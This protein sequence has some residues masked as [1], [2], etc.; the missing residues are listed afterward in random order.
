MSF[1]PH[2]LTLRQLQYVVAIAETRSFREA[3]ERCHV[4]QPALSAQLA[5]LEDA[6]G[7]RIFDRDARRVAA[8]T[9]GAEIVERAKAALR[10]ADEV[11]EAA[12]RVR[13]PLDGRLR[14]GVIPTVSP[15]L[16]PALTAALRAAFPKLVALWVEEKTEVLVRRLDEGSLDA[17]L[18]ALEA[19]LGDVEIERIAS[20]PF[21]L[22]APPTHPLGRATGAIE[23]A[24]LADQPVLLLDDG[25]CFREQALSFCQRTTAHELEFRATSLPTLVQM[26][27]SANAVTLLPTLAVPVEAKHAELVIRP[28]Q[29]KPPARTIVL[30]WR[31]RSAIEEGLRRLAAVVRE[32]YPGGKR[33]R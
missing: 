33:K 6:L 29:G 13:D 32:A 23:P 2:P 30:A 19:E 1:A 9:A 16:V 18:L 31:R 8:T 25:H 24:A 3:A 22:A 10:A 27:G 11:V 21:V 15:Y 7:V 28:F 26:V 5:A 20:D 12:R 17:A 4:S 14:L